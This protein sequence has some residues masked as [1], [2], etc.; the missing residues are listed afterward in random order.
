MESRIVIQDRTTHEGT[1]LLDMY[2]RYGRSPLDV[3][4]TWPPSKLRAAA[5]H[6]TG[7]FAEFLLDVA[8]ANEAAE[9]LRNRLLGYGEAKQLPRPKARKGAVA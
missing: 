6:F 8:D 7:S 5:R 2:H 4:R 9:V 3:Y 1:R